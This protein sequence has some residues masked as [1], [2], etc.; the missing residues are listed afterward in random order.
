M[1]KLSIGVACAAAIAAER[2]GLAMPPM[3]VKPEQRLTANDAP[4]GAAPQDARP[5]TPSKGDAWG[6]RRAL[7][8]LIGEKLLDDDVV[9]GAADAILFERARALLLDN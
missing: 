4:P 2:T 9:S 1:K 8:Y 5:L 6:T 3:P 7:G